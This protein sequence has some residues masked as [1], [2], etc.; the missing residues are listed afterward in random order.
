MIYGDFNITFNLD[1]NKGDINSK[2]IITA[3]NLLGELN[4]LDTPLYGCCFTWTNW[5]TD[6]IWIC[7]DQFFYSYN[8]SLINPRSYQYALSRFG[9]DHSPIC[10]EFGVPYPRSQI[11]RL[12]NSLYTNAHLENLI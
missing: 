10:L 8:W 9:S 7:L 1:K 6:R 12:E 5:Q 11:F 3:Q 2:D 4:V